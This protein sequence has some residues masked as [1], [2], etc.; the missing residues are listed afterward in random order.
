MKN[1]RKMLELASTIAHAKVDQRTFRFGGVAIRD[2]DVL[3]YAC[4]GRTHIPTPSAHCEAR[5]V[6]KLDKG[7]TVYIVRLSKDGQWA[8]SKP[9]PDCVRA[10]RRVQVKKVYYSTGV[11]AWDCLTP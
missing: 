3:V 2:D 5:L 1:P 11:G 8:N 6:R 7:A 4:N 9:C 10:M